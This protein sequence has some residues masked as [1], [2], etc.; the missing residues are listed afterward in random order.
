MKR[1]L[2]VLI[3]L[4]TIVALLAGCAKDEGPL[5]VPKPKPTDPDVPM[6]T[7]F[8]AAGVVPI[9][10]EHC[11]TCHPPMGNDLDL[12]PTNAYTS[13]VNAP[14]SNWPGFLITPGDPEASVLWNKINWHPDYGL[15]MPPGGAP[16]GNV[17][18]ET[19]RAWIEQ[20]AMDN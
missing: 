3:A 10:V 11:W 14:S 7:V 4:G 8:F 2:H 20:G 9:F 5:F 19:I 13:L 12:S 16:L 1:H 17:E 15:G 6:D 18:L